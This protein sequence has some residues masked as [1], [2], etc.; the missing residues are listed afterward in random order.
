MREKFSDEI[1]AATRFRPSICLV[2]PSTNFILG[3]RW[4]RSFQ[5][6]A[7]VLIDLIHRLRGAD[8]RI[9]TLDTGRLNQETYDC[10]EAIRARYGIEVEVFFPEA[11]QVE[12]MVRQHG[13][14]LFYDSI[15][16]RKL[17][18]GIRKVEPLKRASER[19]GRLD[20]GSAPRASGHAH[21]G[22]AKSKSIASTAI[23]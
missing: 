20:D 22:A 13:M 8:F 19:F 18:C 4:R 23:S 7:S 5:A 16:Q 3:S 21:G 17:C 11:T 14:N 1:T 9:F 12:E 15:E 10:M 6:E 2:G